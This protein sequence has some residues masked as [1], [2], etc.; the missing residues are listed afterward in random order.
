MRLKHSI[1]SLV[2]VL[3]LSSVLM[4]SACAAVQEVDDKSFKKEVLEAKTPVLVDFY[5]VWCGPCKAMAPIL[6]ELATEY[7]GK[8]K[9]V[10]VDAEKAT[11]TA[12]KYKVTGFPTMQIFSKNCKETLVLTSRQPKERV[13]QFLDEA[14]KKCA[15]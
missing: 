7:E 1:L 13:K 3:N 6:D 4:Q 8:I 5:T 2:V 15:K 10:K 9:F 11:Q 14:L 12:G